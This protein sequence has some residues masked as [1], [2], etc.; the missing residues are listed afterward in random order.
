MPD[1]TV[2]IRGGS[3]E[4]ECNDDQGKLRFR[5]HHPRTD[6]RIKQVIV[7]GKPVTLDDKDQTI[8]IHFG[9]PES[10]QA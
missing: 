7:S 5:Y 1:E 6:F 3:L 4:I 9:E 2:T 10:S 8:E